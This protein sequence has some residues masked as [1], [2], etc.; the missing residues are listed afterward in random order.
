MDFF[1]NLWDFF[2]EGSPNR[3]WL[4]L[5]W[6]QLRYSIIFKLGQM[7]HGQMLTLQMSPKQLTTHTDGLTIQPSKFGWVLTSSSG[8]MASYLQLNYK[9]PNKNN[10]NNKNKNNKKVNFAKTSSRHCTLGQKKGSRGHTNLIYYV[11]WI[12]KW[13][14]LLESSHWD[15]KKTKVII[16][17]F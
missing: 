12:G 2:L 16:A 10:K 17:F 4:K 7:L 15:K 14:F 11:T 9:D 3:V 13:I 8:D 5:D 6:Y 1:H